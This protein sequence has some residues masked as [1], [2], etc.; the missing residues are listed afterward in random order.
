MGD[1]LC[2]LS[3]RLLYAYCTPIM[4]AAIMGDTHFIYGGHPY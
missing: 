4:E 1:G 3:V 2:T